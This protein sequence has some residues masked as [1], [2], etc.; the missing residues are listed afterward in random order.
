MGLILY[1]VF[2]N[3]CILPLIYSINSFIFYSIGNDY[4]KGFYVFLFMGTGII[5][6]SHTPCK[7]DYA[8]EDKHS[9]TAREFDLVMINDLY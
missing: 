6:L 5:L 7:W 1:Y 8:K 4:E 3:N 2:K 9:E